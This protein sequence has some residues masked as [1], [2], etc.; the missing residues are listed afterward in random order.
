MLF[1]LINLHLIFYS[2]PLQP[3]VG[4]QCLVGKQFLSLL[5]YT[6]SHA[7][8]LLLNNPVAIP[9]ATMPG[10]QLSRT[11]LF[12]ENKSRADEKSVHTANTDPFSPR[13]IAQHH[14]LPLKN[15]LTCY[16]KKHFF[17]FHSCRK[18]LK[19][20]LLGISFQLGIRTG[21]GKKA[22]NCCMSFVR[23]SFELFTTLIVTF[24]GSSF[25]TL[26]YSR[27]ARCHSLVC[28]VRHPFLYVPQRQLF[29]LCLG[30]LGNLPSRPKRK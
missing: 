24:Q 6:S 28:T 13:S 14:V 7:L 12:R 26:D 23:G 25:A 2:I 21:W 4:F 3:L 22:E 10:V 5:L 30:R 19:A 27:S 9:V 8:H 1:E 29:L 16:S 18:K 15:I 11:S 17:L 20:V